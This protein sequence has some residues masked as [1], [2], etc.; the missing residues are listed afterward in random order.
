MLRGAWTSDQDSTEGQFPGSIV[1]GIESMANPFGQLL[2]IQSNSAPS[3]EDKADQEVCRVDYVW[4][5]SAKVAPFLPEGFEIPLVCNEFQGMRRVGSTQGAVSLC[6]HAATAGQAI[7]ESL[8]HLGPER[9]TYHMMRLLFQLGPQLRERLHFRSL[10]NADELRVPRANASGNHADIL[11]DDFGVDIGGAERWPVRRLLEEGKQ[12]A[13]ENGIN[14]PT[15][16]ECIFWG[17]DFEATIHPADLTGLSVAE[18]RNR[19][20][21]ALFDLGSCN[22]VVDDAMKQRVYGRLTDALRKHL[23]LPADDFRRWFFENLDGIVNQIS[24][25]KLPDGKIERQVVRQ[26]ILELVFDS[27]PYVGQT[28]SIFMSSVANDVDPSL[29][30]DEKAVFDALYQHKPCLGNLPLIL[31]HEQFPNIQ[32]AVLAILESPDVP[33]TWGRFLRVLQTYATM[34]VR[35]REA[36]KVKKQSK[37]LKR[38]VTPVFEPVATSDCPSNFDQ[39]ACDFLESQRVRCECSAEPEWETHLKNGTESSPEIELGFEC[40]R[41]GRKNSLSVPRLQFMKFAR[42]IRGLDE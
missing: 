20:R 40:R 37:G 5:P 23:D 13:S 39:I 24:K 8:G 26:T 33:E 2:R 27:W 32:P 10:W 12:A 28:V 42:R 4:R 38:K 25:R 17:V 30:P 16:G 1:D 35:R 36:D 34:V 6:L 9:S 7:R 29:S 22:V 14:C 18:A 21:L 19:L 11:P 31:L 41:C 3:S 15:V